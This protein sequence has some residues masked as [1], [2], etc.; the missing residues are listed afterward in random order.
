MDFKF[1]EGFFPDLKEQSDLGDSLEFPDEN[2]LTGAIKGLV[3][4]QKVYNLTALD[5][6][7]GVINGVKTG[8]KLSK[9]DVFIIGKLLSELKEDYYFAKE[10]LDLALFQ[11]ADK[12]N[13]EVTKKE[14]IETIFSFHLRN[15]EFFKANEALNVL[16]QQER[17]NL[18]QKYWN[19][20]YEA[21]LFENP[22]DETFEP[23]GFYSKEKEQM[24]LRKVCRGEV[25]KSSKEESKLICKY[26]FTNA[27]TKLAPFKVQVAN[28]KPD[29]LLFINAVSH[30][31]IAIVKN[32]F[33]EAQTYPS[34]VNSKDGAGQVNN[35]IQ[36]SDMQWFYDTYN[37]VFNRLTQRTEVR[38]RFFFNLNKCNQ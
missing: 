12:K 38:A 26:H 21:K 18:I 28:I 1:Y 32:L 11:S 35:D 31:E 23:N 14:I 33:L 17:T 16:D 20:F 19:S 3:R 30:N 5:L 4:L 34:Q 8:I 22:R 27:F 36:V 29:V 6:S 10:F 9:H 2:D 37:D 13:N 25:K 7:E 15:N 24:L